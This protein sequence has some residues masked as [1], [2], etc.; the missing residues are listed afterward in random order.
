VESAMSKCEY[1]GMSRPG[2]F[3]IFFGGFLMGMAMH[4]LLH[5]Q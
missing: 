1:C 5:L 2:A 3:L 4:A